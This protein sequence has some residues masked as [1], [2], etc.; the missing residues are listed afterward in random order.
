MWKKSEGFSERDLA[1]LL[2]S[3][4]AQALAKMLQQ[5]DPATLNQAASMAASGNTQGAQALLSPLLK[6][7]KVGKLIQ[8]MEDP[9]G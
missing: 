2:S 8:D 7:P 1:K 3:P 5:M 9:H 6:D 4:Q